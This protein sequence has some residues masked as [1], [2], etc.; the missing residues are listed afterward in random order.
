VSAPSAPD[1]LVVGGGAA[2][3]VLARRLADDPD[4]TV[5][6]LEEG[7]SDE[8]VDVIAHLARWPELLG[9]P[10]Y[11]HDYAIEPQPNGNDRILHS[12]G[13]MLGGCTS[14]NS[15]IS[16]RPPAHDFDTWRDLGARGWGADDVAPYFDRVLERVHLEAS[17][18]GNAA[19]H[20][21]IDAAVHHGFRRRDFAVDVDEGV[22]WFQLAKRGGMRVSSSTA[23]LHPLAGLPPNLEVRTGVRA[24]R[25]L[26]EG[27]RVIGVLTDTGALLAQREVVLCAGAIGSP[28]LLLRS[29]IGP[30]DHLR[31]AGVCPVHDL[32]AVGEHLQ[33]H[34]EG[35]LVFEAA[36]PIPEASAQR[37]EAG[38]FARVDADSPWPDLMFHF[39]TEAFDLHT[40]AAGYP[41]AS[42]AFSI[43][44][45]VTR[46]RSEGTVRLRAGD[47]QGHPA[48]D[49]RYFSDPEGYDERIMVAG[50]EL[51]RELVACPP[52]AGWTARELAPGPD[53]RGF[54]A[55]SRYVRATANTVYHP[56]GTCRMGAENDED[57]VVGPDLRVR[58]LEG[59]RV[60]DASIFPRI[61]STNPQIACMMIGE[62]A[63]D[64][65]RLAT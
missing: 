59:V 8:G 9:D 3:A 61:V 57:A 47:A 33:D 24:L 13:I 48:L 7:P 2:G 65:L 34:P 31:H 63:A 35:V 56:A 54:D 18:H 15:G 21:F 44:P 64:L 46:A 23:Y 30:A 45:N 32:P 17:E 4:V 19:V 60:A 39:G 20:A 14:H 55:I 51:A 38:L 62:R 36:R 53:V 26:L 12:R 27:T 42:N 25:L 43:T 5:M 16:F 10:R 52:L 40:V 50:V 22:G 11:G 49:F 58:G 37:Y 1:Y 41:T 29:G 6:L 28:A